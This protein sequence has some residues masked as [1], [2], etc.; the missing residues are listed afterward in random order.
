[1]ARLLL[2]L[3]LAALCW[4]GETTDVCNIN[5]AKVDWVSCLDE[6][7]KPALP[8]LSALIR[9]IQIPIRNGSFAR[10]AYQITNMHF[11]GA[12]NLTVRKASYG[13]A[14][15]KTFNE[16]KAMSVD[17][18]WQS[19]K[20]AMNVSAKFC[21]YTGPCRQAIARST[22]RFNDATFALAW[23]VWIL[24]NRTTLHKRYVTIPRFFSN[25][26]IRL[27]IGTNSIRDNIKVNSSPDSDFGLAS[28]LWAIVNE[29]WRLYKSD[30]KDQLASK[31]DDWFHDSV[32]P[33]LAKKMIP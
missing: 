21:Y 16:D 31:M 7:M 6:V 2:S 5:K 10:Y 27:E 1:M 32:F 28:N 9:K 30:I 14:E 17:L 29:A 18:E 11:E 12:T 3:L 19:I 33:T 23:K 25:S 20:L 22:L 15:K 24:K 26:R 4:V 13:E 8:D